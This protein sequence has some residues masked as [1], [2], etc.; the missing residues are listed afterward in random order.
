MKIN[1]FNTKENK[2]LGFELSHREYS[3]DLFVPLGSRRS[4]RKFGVGKCYLDQEVMEVWYIN[5]YL[6]RAAFSIEGRFHKIIGRA[7]A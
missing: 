1:V 2:A 4:M 7:K 6:I 3:I 5:L